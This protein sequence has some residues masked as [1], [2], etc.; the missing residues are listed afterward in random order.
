[1]SAD[2]PADPR[3]AVPIPATGYLWAE[4]LEDADDVTPWVLVH[5]YGQDAQDLV[6][7]AQGF[8]PARTPIVAPEGPDAFYRR[9]RGGPGAS[10]RGIAHGWLAEP[11]RADAERR[12]DA[13]LRH[14]LDL[15]L[16]G[17]SATGA[18]LLGYSQ[19]VGV[20]THAAV[21]DRARVRGLVGLAGGI[22]MLWRDQLHALA[23]L[24]VLWV[25]G[26]LD[27][28]YPPAYEALVVEALEAGG[29]HVAHVALDAGHDLLAA[30][31]PHVRA[32]M[33]GLLGAG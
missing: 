7:W 27:E 1:M 3:R 20:A 31:V 24:P 4:G 23:G 33:A 5:G 11:R 17:R 9:P 22:P 18:V 28:S 10:T 12:N 13:L 25:T 19:G 30:A 29:A 15:A 8:L 14:A 6:A 26:A 32:W 21:V 2:H 16:Q